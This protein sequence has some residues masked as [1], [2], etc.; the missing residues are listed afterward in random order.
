MTAAR[1]SGV[2]AAG[3]GRIPPVASEATD[4]GLAAVFDVFRDAGRDVPMLYRTLANAPAML[5]GWTDLA[6][7][8]RQDAVAPRRLRELVIMRVAQLTAAPFEWLAHWGMAM[9]HGISEEQLGALS[10]WQSS[11]QF[12]DEERA[13]LAMTDGLTRELDV[14]DAT[15]SA[16]AAQFSHGELVEL[17]LTAAFYSCVSRVLHAFRL[18]VVDETDPRLALLSGR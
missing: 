12:S 13:V 6:W 18:G 11:T 17:V 2:P 1:D 7:A 10:S 15:W 9:K 3:P 4:P 14:S 5:Q 16:L 8:L